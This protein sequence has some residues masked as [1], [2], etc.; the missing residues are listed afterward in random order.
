MRSKAKK[1]PRGVGLGPQEAATKPAGSGFV[2]TPIVPRQRSHV[3]PSPANLIAEL[4]N[5]RRA[6]NVAVL[7]DDH[8]TAA[9]WQRRYHDL[10][11]KRRAELLE[12]V[13][14]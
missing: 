12:G 14:S 6:Y 2:S 3:N 7:A 11:A 10:E 4:S 13:R 9:A 5:A 1:M 8:E